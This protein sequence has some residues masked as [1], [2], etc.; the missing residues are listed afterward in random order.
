[1]TIDTAKENKEQTALQYWRER[2]GFKQDEFAQL[3][4]VQRPILSQWENGHSLPPRAVR[5]RISE[6]LEKPITMLFDLI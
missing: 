5:E 2:R 6:L 3:L 4:G 1:M